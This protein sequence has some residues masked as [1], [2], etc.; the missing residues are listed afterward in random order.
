MVQFAPGTA[1]LQ[2]FVLI[3]RKFAM[4]MGAFSAIWQER[5][6]RMMKATTRLGPFQPS[7]QAKSGLWLNCWML[8]PFVG[9][10]C[11]RLL[12]LTVPAWLILVPPS[13]AQTSSDPIAECRKLLPTAQIACLE[14]AIRAIANERD[15][16][17]AQPAREASTLKAAPAIPP[18]AAQ[19]ASLPPG[20]ELG[21]EQVRTRNTKVQKSD[22]APNR[23]LSAK[24]RDHFL[25]NIGTQVFVL[26]NGQIWRQTRGDPATRR[27]KP[28]KPYQVEIAPGLISGYRLRVRELHEIFI[29][30][31]LR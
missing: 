16:T 27:L 28:G 26:E 5:R 4:I 24:L 11:A 3:C 9:N 30:E 2:V 23:V 17:Q 14:D 31:R 19:Q 29:V 8:V 15:Q 10:A 25:T 1:I 20:D 12:A 13:F 18:Y 21:A 6:H 7:A 22:K